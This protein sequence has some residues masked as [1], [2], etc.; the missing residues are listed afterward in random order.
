MS[1]HISVM[2]RLTVQRIHSSD[3]ALTPEEIIERLES[4]LGPAV[5]RGFP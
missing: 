2:Q 5:L 1:Y 3:I 4:L